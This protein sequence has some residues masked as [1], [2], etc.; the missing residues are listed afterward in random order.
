MSQWYEVKDA[1][2]VELSD[3]GKTVE[4]LFDTD[5]NGNRYVTV[6]V[7]VLARLLFPAWQPVCTL[8]G[9]PWQECFCLRR[10]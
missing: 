4:I 3:D 2:D 10:R 1:D 9:K 6:P 7:E 5:D 8:C